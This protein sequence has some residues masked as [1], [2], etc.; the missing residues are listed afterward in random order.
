MTHMLPLL[1]LTLLA[2]TTL[3]QDNPT[4]VPVV[5]PSANFELVGELGT[6]LGSTVTL[7]GIIVEGRFKG[8]EGGP[9][10]LVQKIDGVGTQRVVQL[11]VSPYFGK[12]GE[13]ISDKAALPKIANGLTFRLRGY[14]TGGFVGI[15][16]DAYGEAGIPLQTTGFYFRNSFVVFNGEKIDA[17]VWSPLDFIDKDALLSGTARNHNDSAMIESDSWKLLVD[18]V[19]K[20]DE[21]EVGKLAE[22]FGTVSKTA[23]ENVFTLKNAS[24]RLVLLG[25]QVG[26]PVVLRGTA[27]SLNGHW[28]FNYRGTDM[29]V[30]KMSE[31]P[32]WT[33]NN[34][35]RPIEIFGNLEEDLLPRIDQISLKHERDL[36][37]YYIVRNPKWKPID[38]LLTPET[39]PKK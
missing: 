16:S 7:E 25:D 11:P 28:W 21:S 24:K 36:K 8:Y 35:W 3:A 13:K 39:P 5:P 20:W 31:L 17:L 29:Y 10:L 33:G 22:A 12:F 15:P 34:H 19:E 26:R 27:R 38:G 23:S 4:K 9:N 37:K 14:E 30:E 6:K 32:N 1:C 2:S 18:G